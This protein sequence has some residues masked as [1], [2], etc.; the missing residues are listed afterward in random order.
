VWV[1]VVLL[2]L[3]AHPGGDVGALPQRAGVRPDL[4]AGTERVGGEGARDVGGGGAAAVEEGLDV[5]R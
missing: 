4:H 1:D 3:Q 5:P 2:H